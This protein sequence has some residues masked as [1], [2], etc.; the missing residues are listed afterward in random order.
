MS[1]TKE[2]LELTDMGFYYYKGKVPES[3]YVE[4]GCFIP[5]KAEWFV[6]P[7]SKKHKNTL[8]ICLGCPKRCRATDPEGWQLMLPVKK[9]FPGEIALAVVESISADELLR[10]KKV[11][12][13]NEAAWALNISRQQVH[14]WIQQGI[15]DQVPGAPIRVT[16]ESVQRNLTAV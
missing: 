5:K 10:I 14:E 6:R 8:F 1:K 9:N 11:L 7:W 4:Q 13:V 16:V 2:I 15:L 12:R 3:F